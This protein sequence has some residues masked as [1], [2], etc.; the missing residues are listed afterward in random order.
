MSSEGLFTGSLFTPT[1]HFLTDVRIRKWKKT[2]SH[3][4]SERSCC[5]WLVY[6]YRLVWVFLFCSSLACDLKKIPHVF[7]NFTNSKA[8]LPTAEKNSVKKYSFRKPS[9]RVQETKRLVISSMMND[10]TDPIW[11]VR[12]TERRHRR[13]CIDKQIGRGETTAT[14]PSSLTG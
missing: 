10:D 13:T 9:R 4:N 7:N 5:F 6:R 14:V 11:F 2:G 1:L 8:R 3:I 12:N